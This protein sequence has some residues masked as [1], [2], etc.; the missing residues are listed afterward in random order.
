VAAQTFHDL[1]ALADRRPEVAGTLDE[2][3]LVQV[4]R[5][6]PVLDELVDESLLDV[7]AVVDAREQDRL[8]AQ[9]DAGS[10]QLVAGTGNLGRDLVRMI[11]VEVHPQRVVLRQHFAQLVVDALRQEDGHPGADA[12]DLDVRDLAQAAKDRFEEL[13]GKRQGVAAGEEHVADLRGAAQIVELGLD[14]VA[15]EVLAGIAH[16][17]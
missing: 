9:R 5:P 16:D 14:V 4:V 8:V 3:A 15:I 13:G 7:E 17:P 6:D 1:D 2:I 11:E 10:G 12:D